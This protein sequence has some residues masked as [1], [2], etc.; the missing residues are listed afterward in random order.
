[1]Q[2]QESWRQPNGLYKCPFCGKEFKLMA[3]NGHIIRAHQDNTQPTDSTN[4]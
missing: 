3:I 1:M 2:I 4:N